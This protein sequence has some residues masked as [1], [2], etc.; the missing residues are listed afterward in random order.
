MLDTLSLPHVT[1]GSP[2]SPRMPLEPPLEDPP[3]DDPP[4][5]EPELAVLLWVPPHAR[6]AETKKKGR[7]VL[8]RG[9]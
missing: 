5:E 8:I 7:S 9:P 2:A 1:D 6:K 3:L 4:L